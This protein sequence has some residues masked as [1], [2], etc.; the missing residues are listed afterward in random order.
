[1]GKSRNGRRQ[2]LEQKNNNNKEGKF[3]KKGVTKEER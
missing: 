2:E 3:N 1:M